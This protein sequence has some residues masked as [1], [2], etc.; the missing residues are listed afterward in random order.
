MK[1]V[2]TWGIAE[3]Q[4]RLAAFD[5]ALHEANI[6]N[7]N[8]IKVTSIVPPGSTISVRRYGFRP[9]EFGHKAYVLLSSGIEVKTGCEIWAGLG[10]LTEKSSA[11]GII[12]EQKANT[13]ERV[14]CK[15]EDTLTCMRSYRS[16]LDSEIECK[17]I[18]GKCEGRPI[19]ALVCAVFN[20]ESW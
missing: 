6:G 19:C 11:R 9:I 2:I 4:T 15:I 20:I 16:Y 8:L 3:G 10:W 1:I 17:I 13:R 7:Y 12:V 14:I 5:Q 18:G